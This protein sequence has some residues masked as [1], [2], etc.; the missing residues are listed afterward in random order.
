MIEL[1]IV[2][3]MSETSD[4]NAESNDVSAAASSSHVS[5]ED[6]YRFLSAE[7]SGMDFRH[8]IGGSTSHEPS[9]LQRANSTPSIPGQHFQLP[10]SASDN[11]S[12]ASTAATSPL[13]TSSASGYEADRRRRNTIASARFR[14]RRRERND[15][16]ASSRHHF[17][18]QIESLNVRIHE[19]ELENQYLR[20]LV[21]ETKRV[22]R[23]SD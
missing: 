16:L 22:R 14:E 18:Q 5:T 12:V 4:K 15:S 11:V 21:L 6:W 19:L 3:N 1:Q 9:I 23:K 20:G 2:I 8:G 17:I 10:P 7:M 13:N